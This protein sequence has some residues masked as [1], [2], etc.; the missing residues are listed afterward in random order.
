MSGELM[1]YSLACALFLTILATIIEITLRAGCSVRAA[2]NQHYLFFFLIQLVGNCL[3][4]LLA[5]WLF[6][7]KFPS[8]PAEVSP[9]FFSVVGVFAFEF[10]LSNTNINLH[11]D[12]A[13]KIQEFIDMA[14]LP[15]IA[16]AN[17]KEAE[18][19][20]EKRIQIAEKISAAYTEDR[21]GVLINALMDDDEF[22]LLN[23][24][25]QQHNQEAHFFKCLIYVSLN[26]DGAKA[27]AKRSKKSKKLK[28]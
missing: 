24:R 8:L 20:A 19:R 5:A 26:Y 25:A 27:L 6:I 15:T 3:S 4:T 7:D 2:I 12:N 28:N 10:V 16:R 17:E 1:L 23:D 14:K 22:K 18:L 11:K 9:L 13:I 21:I